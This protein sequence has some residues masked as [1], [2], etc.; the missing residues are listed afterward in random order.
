MDRRMKRREQA[1]GQLAQSLVE[2]ESCLAKLKHSEEEKLSTSI[3]NSQLVEQISKL[4][5]LEEQANQGNE[6][7]MLKH[8]ILLN[9]SLRQQEIGFKAS[10]KAQLQDLNA[11][12]EVLES[13]VED[14]QEEDKKLAD[15]ENMYNQVTSKYNR[16]RQVLA[17]ANLEVASTV[18]TIDDIPTRT[19]LIQYERRFF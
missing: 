10:C 4:T 5:E 3:Y 11:K 8:L 1:C 9:E 17:D 19:E 2:V 13:T 14:V 6:L 15:I 12:A 7:N 18:R 16:L